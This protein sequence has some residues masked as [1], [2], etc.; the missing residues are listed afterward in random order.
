[1]VHHAEPD[2]V[3]YQGVH[4]VVYQ[5]AVVIVAGAVHCSNDTVVGF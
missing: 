2:V 5:G 4:V 3:V 1:M